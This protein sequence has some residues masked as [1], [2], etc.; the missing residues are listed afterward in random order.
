MQFD[1]TEIMTI[2]MKHQH[3]I[4]NILLNNRINN[5]SKNIVDVTKTGISH[6]IVL[7]AFSLLQH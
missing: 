6:K 3:D 1:I 2:Y 5:N 7:E 4:S